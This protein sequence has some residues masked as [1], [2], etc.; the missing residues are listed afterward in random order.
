LLLGDPPSAAR[1]WRA[2]ILAGAS[3]RS[4]APII[5]RH[6]TPSVSR[7]CDGIGIRRRRW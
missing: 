1:R 6:F 7:L 5:S 3:P 4:S 2:R